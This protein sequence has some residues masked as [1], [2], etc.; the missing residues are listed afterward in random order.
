MVTTNKKYKINITI[1]FL[2]FLTVGSDIAM[3]ASKARK[4]SSGKQTASRNSKSNARKS[5]SARSKANTSDTNISMTNIATNISKESEINSDINEDNCE[6]KYNLCMNNIC[7]D[8]DIGKCLCYED[9]YTNK[10]NQSFININGN[11][12]RKGFELLEYAKKQCVYILDKCMNIRRSITEKYSN[13][14][15]RDCLMVSQTEVA[16]DQGLSAEINELKKCVRDYCTASNMG[17][18]D[19]SMPEYGLCFDP[20]VANF[21]IDANCSSIIAKS[22]TPV[23]LRDLFLNDM[24]RLREEACKKMNG[25]M[26]NDRQKCYITVSYGPNKDSIASS[27]KIAVGEY[28]YCNGKEFNTDL[29]LSEEFER[30]KKHEK[31]LLA[32][33]G[34]RAAGNIVGFVVGESVIGKVVETSIDVTTAVAQTYVDIEATAKGYKSKQ[35]GITSIFNNVSSVLLTSINLANV[36][37]AVDEKD[38]KL[39]GKGADKSAE[40]STE[41]ASEENKTDSASTGNDSSSSDK[42]EKS[43]TEPVKTEDGSS[44]S[45]KEKS[46]TE[47]KESS[48]ASSVLGI[49]S[50]AVDVAGGI[51][52]YALQ[53]KIDDITIDNEKKGVV[54]YATFQNRDEGI[55]TVNKTASARGNCFINNEW[56]ATENE[57]ILLQWQL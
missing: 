9:K 7:N 41:S 18:E 38:I 4:S 42:S 2:G 24:T 47:S 29:G 43:G 20:E 23:G 37:S 25:E 49:A 52:G 46:K 16:K 1:L 53:S 15:Q 21:Q 33:K 56:L 12:V 17:Y 48:T 34:L 10:S 54:D 8:P 6:F 13:L 26:S 5:S 39:K 11:N 19:F 32:A 40:N 31:I 55:G 28:F 57:I 22:K 35:E 27:K 30:K 44:T 50:S 14:V 3:S 51:T 36:I 45:D